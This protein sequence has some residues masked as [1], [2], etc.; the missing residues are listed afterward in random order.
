MKKDKEDLAA[1]LKEVEDDL[2]VSGL[3]HVKE[4]M[5]QFVCPCVCREKGNAKSESEDKLRDQSV[6]SEEEL[7]AIKKEKENNCSTAE[8]G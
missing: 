8:D 1:Q 6:K 2:A 4:S 5:F 7:R 3:L